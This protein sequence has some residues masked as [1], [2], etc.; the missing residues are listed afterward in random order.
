MIVLGLTGPSGAGKGM[1]G[2]AFSRFGVPALDTDAIYHTLLCPPS[3]CLDALTA[4]FGTAIL[5]QDGT[6]NRA[7]LAAL[8]FS[9]DAPPEYHHRLNSITHHYIL[10]ETRRQMTQLRRQGVPAV[11]IDAPLLY[12][13]GFDAECDFV[14]AVTAPRDMRIDR[15]L[16]RDGITREAALARLAAQHDDS[17]YTARAHFV[18]CNDGSLDRLDRE[19]QK[20]LC[21]LGVIPA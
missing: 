14:I 8:V 4:Q 17:F 19:A 6:L 21:R 11:L 13:S 1:L 9:P 16:A 18:V 12:E 2:L 3:A 10:T 7:A 20:I 5:R 15:I